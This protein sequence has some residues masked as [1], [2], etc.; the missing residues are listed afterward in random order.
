M[1]TMDLEIISEKLSWKM[2]A[3]K[4]F[5]KIEYLFHILVCILMMGAFF[6]MF[7]NFFGKQ[8]GLLEGDPLQRTVLTA[9]YVLALLALCFHLREALF[10]IAA[11]P[12]IWLLLLWAVL[13]VLWS[14]FPEVAFRRVLA[15]WLTSLYGLVLVL[16]FEFK[17]LLRL[18]GG[19]LLAVMVG[20][21]V[22]L[23][24]FPEWAI[25]GKPLLGNWRG[26]FIHKNHLGRFSAL[27]LLV[28]GYLIVMNRNT[29][30]KIV[31]GLL[32]AISLIT[33][34][35]S[36]SLGAQVIVVIMTVSILFFKTFFSKK[37]NA[38]LWLLLLGLILAV[39]VFYFLTNYDR[40]M[41][42]E[43]AKDSSLSGRV[44]LW[45]MLVDKI[46][47]QPLLGYGYGSFW[48]GTVGPAAEIWKNLD[49]EAPHAHNGYLDLWLQLGFLGICLGLY[50]LLRLCIL[51]VKHHAA[52][53][54]AG[55]FW[56]LFM[57][58]FICYNMI[59]SIFLTANGLFWVLL[60]YGY[61][62]LNDGHFSPLPNRAGKDEIILSR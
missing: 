38:R 7:R 31:W 40:I 45:R 22:L 12:A 54:P 52:T 57:A 10:M 5:R 6:P 41:V 21:L 9:A 34:V 49:W 26:V 29:L 17:Q 18:L 33:L 56:I 53:G 14:D 58:F 51:S 36:Q 27:A 44:P 1:K 19:A 11:T 16:R 25:M 35:G 23:I 46:S 32:A 3:R 30:E 43:F 13:S 4:T 62:Y 60:V 47:R 59:E 8:P 28:A 37:K 42:E 55:Q 15:I 50:L 20:S 39:T 48:V 24:L 2:S 61:V